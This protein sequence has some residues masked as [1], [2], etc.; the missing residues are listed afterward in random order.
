MTKETLNPMEDQRLMDAS[1]LGKLIGRSTK[2]IKVDA[3]RRPHTLP[4][5]FQIPGTAAQKWRVY[6]VRRWMEA[7]A[8]VQE[9][10]RIKARN[11]ALATGT[12][13]PGRRS[14][15]LGR[16]RTGMAATA[17]MQKTDAA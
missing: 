16:D 17:Q 3:T 2:S 5:R 13:V 9:Q 15:V 12:P 7:L 10:E 4:P 8:Q 11:L 14:F 6:D 1:E